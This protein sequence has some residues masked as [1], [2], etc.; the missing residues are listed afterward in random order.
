MIKI[1]YDL[2]KGCM[3]CVKSCPWGVLEELDKMPVV[4]NAANCATCLACVTACP[5]K[6]IEI[7]EDNFKKCKMH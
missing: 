2:C 1:N 5:T 6:A 4:M 3:K 7:T